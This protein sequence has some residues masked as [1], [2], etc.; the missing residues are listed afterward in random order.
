MQLDPTREEQESAQATVC[1]ALETRPERAGAGAAMEG[2]AV[3]TSTTKGSMEIQQY[4][5]ALERSGAASRTI[6]AFTRLSLDN[7]QLRS[8]LHGT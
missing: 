7:A 4:L 5:E 1:L 8:E 3:V 2:E 6:A